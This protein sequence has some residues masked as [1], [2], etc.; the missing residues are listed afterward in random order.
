MPNVTPRLVVEAFE[1]PR[2]GGRVGYLIVPQ[3]ELLA[4]GFPNGIRSARVYRGPG[5]PAGPNFRAVFFEQPNF[6]GRKLALGP[7][8]YPNLV[9]MSDRFSGQ[10]A[11]VNFAPDLDI[12][13]PVWGTIPLYVEVYEGVMFRG[14]KAVVLRDNA[15]THTTLGMADTIRS[16]RVLKGP[17]F[18]PQ[19]A[20]VRLYEHIDFEGSYLEIA[21]TTASQRKEVPDLS[22]IQ[23]VGGQ[24]ASTFGSSI[25]S[26]QIEGWASSGQFTQLVFSDEFSDEQMR[27]TWRWVAPAGGGVWAARQGY[28]EM[29]VQPGRDLWHG[30]PPGQ[31]GN[32]D[33]P[34]LVMDVQGDFAIETRIRVTPQLREHGGLLVWANP[35]RFLRLEKTSGP[36]GFRGD[37]RF[38][39]HVQRVFS[40]VGR[41]AGLVNV[42]HLFLRLERIGNQFTGLASADGQN[43]QNCG[44]TSVAMGNPVQVGL[45]A[46][47][48]GNIPPTLTR[49][50]YFRVYKRP[51]EG[52]AIGPTPVAAGLE[53]Q[54]S[55]TQRLL[56]MRRLMR[57]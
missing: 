51:G 54:M 39:Q 4:V 19:G 1:H 26:I 38:E 40:L 50:D 46:L 6:Q 9:D 41:G 55:P 57:S 37:V 35:G 10:A 5:Y 53:Q 21:M 52:R 27:P 23:M 48:P 3:R 36:H 7:G 18:P 45:H 28:L 15:N 2:Y 13:G 56:M 17:N 25:S 34:R 33:A 8:Y 11:S 47:C 42:R 22:L 12:G 16:V 29:Q 14:R 43:W 31:G 20:H 49:F 44:A 24:Y 30:N 32:M